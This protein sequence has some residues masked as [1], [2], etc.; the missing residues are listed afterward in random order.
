MTEALAGGQNRCGLVAIL[1]APN[2]G[3][4]TLLNRLVGSKISIVTPKVQTTRARV[5]GIVM[6]GA[7]QI[8]FVDTPGIF[9]PKRRL[10]RAMVQAAWRG[11]GDADVILLLVDAK[12]GLDSDTRRII[13]GLASG[14]RRAVVALNKIDL[15][16]RPRLLDLAQAVAATGV[17]SRVFMIAGA[18]GDG[19]DDLLNYLAAALPEGPWLFP[20]DQASDIPLRQLAAEI[21]REKL[22]LRLRQELP[23]ALT[24]ETESWEDFTDGS[25]KINQVIYLHRDSHKPIVLGRGGQAI[26]A[27][28]EVAQA[29]LAAM[30][31]RPV[32]LFLFVKVRPD[33]LEDPERYRGIGLDFTD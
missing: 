29:E 33:W 31:E 20:P 16:H 12:Q 2:A 6:R 23:Y 30:F 17:A 8:V 25:V 32:H 10:E 4:S 15:V 1:G 11:A 24:V 7:T 3:K 5:L 13:A 26:K 14:G 18:T 19:T 9:A 22:F 21:T 28:R 27:V